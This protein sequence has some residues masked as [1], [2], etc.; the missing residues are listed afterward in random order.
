MTALDRR[1][2][3]VGSLAA[4]A[5]VVVPRSALAAQEGSP[6]GSLEGVAADANGIVLPDGFT[7]EVVA[8]TGDT[9]GDGSYPW[10]AFPDGGA[11]YSTADGGW[12]YVSNSEHIE[13]GAG[14]AG[15]VAFAPDGTARTSYQ[16]LDGTTRN[17]AGG[18]TPWGTWLSC[19]EFEF[20]VGESLPDGL[21]ERAGRVWEC[22]PTGTRDATVLPALG[23]FSHEAVAVDP[24]RQQLYL[25]EDQLDSLLYRFT[26]DAYPD[27]STGLLEAAI[28]DDAGG[29]TW[30]E[31]PDPSA[32]ETNC[33]SQ[34]P[35]ATPFAGGEGVWYENGT[36][37]LTTKFDGKIHAYEVEPSTISVLYD[38]GAL[39]DDAPLRGLDNLVG[40]GAGDLF[41]AEDLRGQDPVE[42]VLVTDTGLVA[43]FLQVTG[44]DTELTGPAFSPDG[45]RLYFS[46]QTATSLTEGITYGVTGPFR[47][48]DSVSAPPAGGTTT[49]TTSTTVPTTTTSVGADTAPA[50]TSTALD[51]VNEA[52][53]GGEDD[54]GNALLVGG[55]V[56]AAA[57]A[58]GGALAWRSRRDRAGESSDGE[59]RDPSPS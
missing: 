45:T 32:T 30:A 58:A 15:A 20:P 23:V 48:A 55:L 52:A 57:I 46:S 13:P 35:G 17:C 11:T 3:L 54:N 10:H 39:G 27:L 25:S 38:G 26:P 18:A 4:G 9:V 43:P 50:P 8:R 2:F 41:V 22:D 44:Q 6:Y 42:I 56:G 47:H 37:F 16:I 19:E 24:D 36:V 28:V 1:G 51:A 29:V 53:D 5:A 31:V 49:T 34:V 59:D 33:R 14:G 21:D 12:I 7:S 40:D